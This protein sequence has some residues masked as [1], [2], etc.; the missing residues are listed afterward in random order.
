[1][2]IKA[3]IT[4]TVLDHL[5]ITGCFLLVLLFIYFFLLSIMDCF[6]KHCKVGRVVQC[7]LALF[8][9]DNTGHQMKNKRNNYKFLP[10]NLSLD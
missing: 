10:L 4:D 5:Y 8:Y 3:V 2:K 9:R 1:M 7:D 6:M